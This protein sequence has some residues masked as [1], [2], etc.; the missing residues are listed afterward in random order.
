MNRGNQPCAA[1]GRQLCRGYSRSFGYEQGDTD[2][3]GEKVWPGMKRSRHFLLHLQ[4]HRLQCWYNICQ[5]SAPMQG[6]HP[7]WHGW[8]Y[9]GVNRRDVLPLGTLTF[10][11]W[12]SGHHTL[13]VHILLR[14]G[15]M[16]QHP[17]L[18]QAS[19]LGIGRYFVS[20]A[21]SFKWF[22]HN[23]TWWQGAECLCLGGRT[24]SMSC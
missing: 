12:T 19:T 1:N 24:A 23:W 18:S 20:Q 17:W 11:P 4:S 15:L 9:S 21:Y 10:V 16:K 14:G 7:S 13:H 22:A 8:D 2:G 6:F 3:Y 5:G